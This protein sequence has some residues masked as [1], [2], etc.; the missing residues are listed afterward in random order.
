M[1][2]HQPIRRNSPPAGVEIPDKLYFR[3]GEVSRL[4]DIPAYVL[5]FWESEF[6]QLKPHKGGTGQRLYRRRDVEAVLHIKSLLYDEGYTIS[7]AR[8]VI[9]TE[10]RQK[11]PQ[12]SLGIDVATSSSTKAPSLRKLQ[13]EM[14]DL[15]AHLSRPPARSSVQSIRSTR[16]TRPENSK[17]FDPGD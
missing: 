3:I 13:K 6:P 16:S 17:L 7:G 2:Q 9:K 12:L 1:A 8:Q 11:A 15:L 14:R 5:R 4:C 10:Q